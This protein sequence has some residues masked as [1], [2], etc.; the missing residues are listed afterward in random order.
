MVDD[1]PERVDNFLKRLTTMKN[2]AV[3]CLSGW[4]CKTS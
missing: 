1:I 3:V 2:T 4:R